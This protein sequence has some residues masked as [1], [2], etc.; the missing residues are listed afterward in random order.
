MKKMFLI[1]ALSLFS[2]SSFAQSFDNQQPKTRAQ[3]K[4]ELAELEQAGYNPNDWIDYPENIQ[5][6]EKIVWQK[7]HSEQN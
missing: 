7:H 3:V 6:A 4:Q 1:T 5:A 2:M